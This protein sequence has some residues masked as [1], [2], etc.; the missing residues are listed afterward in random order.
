MVS[1]L[2]YDFRLILHDALL[3]VIRHLKSSSQ[4]LLTRRQREGGN[5]KKEEVS[6][7]RFEEG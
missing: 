5:G 2:K 1:K 3:L 7:M 4:D 6:Q